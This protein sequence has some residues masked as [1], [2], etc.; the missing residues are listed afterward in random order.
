MAENR[1]TRAWKDSLAKRA[2]KIKKRHRKERIYHGIDT[3]ASTT[4]F[5]DDSSSGDETVS[6]ECSYE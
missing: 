3:N 6:D 5:N 1:K 2:E 4:Q